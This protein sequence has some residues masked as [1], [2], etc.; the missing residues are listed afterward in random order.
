MKTREEAANFIHEQLNYR[1]KCPRNKGRNFHYG[2]QELRVLMD[3][4]YEGAP[5]SKEEEIKINAE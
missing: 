4:I 3:Y 2:I 1:Y 5:Q